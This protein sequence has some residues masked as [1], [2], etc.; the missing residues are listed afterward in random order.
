[1]STT[2]RMG[3]GTPYYEGGV[4]GNFPFLETNEATASAVYDEALSFGPD[5]TFGTAPASAN[6]TVTYTPASAGAVQTFNL[7]AAGG[8]GTVSFYEGWPPE[9]NPGVYELAFVLDGIPAENTL[10]LAVAIGMGG[11]TYGNLSWYSDA[12]APPFTEFWTR[13]VGAQETPT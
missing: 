12:A 4:P 6:V 10:V 3:W 13:F 2:T 1:M 11:S 7:V 9:V 8:Q 5:L